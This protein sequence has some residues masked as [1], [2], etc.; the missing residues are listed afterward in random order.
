MIAFDLEVKSIEQSKLEGVKVATAEG[1]GER[2]T[3]DVIED[4]YVLDQ[5]Q[6]V[7]LVVSEEKP[8]DIDSYDFCGHGY[9]VTDEGKGY[10]LLSLWGIL[11]KFEPP[12]GLKMNQKYYLCLKRT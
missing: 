10:T 6:K 9:L 3:F 7:R 1:G 5:G 2:V 8:S 4:L 11:F 12:I